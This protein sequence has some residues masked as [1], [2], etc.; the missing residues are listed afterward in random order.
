MATGA[1]TARAALR[2]HFEVDRN[3]IALAALKALADEGKID[4]NDRDARPSTTLGID[5]AKADPLNP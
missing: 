1:A 2:R 3:F 4:R 5:P